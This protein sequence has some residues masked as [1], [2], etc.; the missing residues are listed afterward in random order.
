MYVL[1][2][3]KSHTGWRHQPVCMQRIM[4]DT[5]EFV[6]TA[7]HRFSW[8]TPLFFYDGFLVM[9]LF[10]F[11]SRTFVYC[12]SRSVMRGLRAGRWCGRDPA[13]RRSVVSI[14]SGTVLLHCHRNRMEENSSKWQL[15]IITEAVFGEFAQ[16]L[17]E[18]EVSRESERVEN[19]PG[20]QLSRI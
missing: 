20:F 18:R 17:M 19:K 13:L 7:D 11:F 12:S 1:E 4:Y 5:R 3:K 10:L 2:A 14:S 6:S 9:F 15:G 16:E 8:E